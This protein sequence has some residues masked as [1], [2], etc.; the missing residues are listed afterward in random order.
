MDKDNSHGQMVEFTMG[1]G[2]MV[3][4]MVLDYIPMK[5]GSSRLDNGKR[6]RDRNGYKR[7]DQK[8][9]LI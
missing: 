8:N 3:N 6:V 7:I 9:S 5:M 2:W 4:K 1:N